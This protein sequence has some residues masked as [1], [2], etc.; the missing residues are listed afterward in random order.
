MIKLIAFITL[1][2]ANA[3]SQTPTV[4]FGESELPNHKPDSFLVVQPEGSP[5]PLGNPI[6]MIPHNNLQE[7]NEQNQNLNEAN[8]V[9]DVQNLNQKQIEQ[10][11]E[12]N[13][14]PFSSTPEQLENKIENTL[15]QGGNRIYDIQ[16]FP[17]KDIKEITEPNIQPTITDYPDY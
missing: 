15:Y 1:L 16:S 12:Q 11:S 4:V 2:S 10:I 13:P 14:P 7:N 17:I 3:Y 8:N 6:V 5:N 9:S